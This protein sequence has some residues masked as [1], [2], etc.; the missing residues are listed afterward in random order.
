M[1]DNNLTPDEL[2]ALLSTAL[3]N[4]LLSKIKSGDA[5]ASDLQ[6]CLN[7]VKYHSIQDA[8][9]GLKVAEALKGFSF[10]FSDDPH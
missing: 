2:A 3:G 10:P 9:Q 7:F 4:E 1:K 6:V 5:K 8:D